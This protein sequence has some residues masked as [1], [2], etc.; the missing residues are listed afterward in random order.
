MP[1]SASTMS[2]RSLRM[3]ST[4]CFPSPTTVTWTSS[5]AKVSSITRWI[6]TLSSASSNLCAIS[7]S[8][9]AGP[10]VPRDEVDDLLHRRAG[11][12]DPLHSRVTE[13]RDVDVRNDPAHHDEH[14]VQPLLAQQLH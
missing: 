14:V 3:R 8:F 1:I 7:N 13:L 9:R 11:Q 6:V 5:S 2:G 12:E 10:D 4:A